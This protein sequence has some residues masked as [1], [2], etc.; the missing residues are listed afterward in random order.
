MRHVARLAAPTKAAGTVAGPVTLR[1]R[2][3]A[4]ATA[5]GS[6]P[7]SL[8]EVSEEAADTLLTHWCTGLRKVLMGSGL[9]NKMDTGA[10]VAALA[11]LR[12]AQPSDGSDILAFW[13]ALYL[14]VALES[15]V[16][17]SAQAP[18]QVGIELGRLA[19]AC[20]DAGLVGYSDAI[21]VQT[22]V[23]TAAPWSDAGPTFEA[24]SAP[25][26]ADEVTPWTLFS[27]PGL[28]EHACSAAEQLEEGGG[29]CGGRPAGAAMQPG[30]LDETGRSNP[31]LRGDV[32]RWL[33]GEEVGRG[34]GGSPCVGAMAQLLR[35]AVLSE[36]MAA[37]PGVPLIHPK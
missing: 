8:R 1:P 7:F 27:S 24:P 28:R 16:L 3:V 29:G 35:S 22:F 18:R 36:L 25:A 10:A 11:E 33:T 13:S 17:F 32:I 34:R 12:D 14:S 19:G 31:A 2:P 6:R 37:L 15:E 5:P 26:T 20:A 30:E 21:L 4:R 9:P 23:N